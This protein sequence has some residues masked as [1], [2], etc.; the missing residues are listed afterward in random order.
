MGKTKEYYVGVATH[1]RT[2]ID[3]LRAMLIAYT[4][5]SFFGGCFS[6]AAPKNS[7][8]L[9]HYAHD[10]SLT[11]PTKFIESLNVCWQA[12]FSAHPVSKK[13]DVLGL[14]LCVLLEAIQ[15]VITSESYK[16]SLKDKN[17]KLQVSTLLLDQECKKNDARVFSLAPVTNAQ[18]AAMDTIVQEPSSFS[19]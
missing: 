14:E 17:G 10:T 12:E 19:F 3:A 5:S 7:D 18:G 16:T 9:G 13:R 11:A 15:E 1:Q 4:S 2:L 6:C 8:V